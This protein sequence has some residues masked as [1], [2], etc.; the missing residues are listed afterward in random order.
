MEGFFD[1]LDARQLEILKEQMKRFESF[2]GEKRE[3]VIIDGDVILPE[4][5]LIHGTPFNEK[6]LEN[7]AKS[8]I[9]TGEY[10]G[11]SEDGETFYHADF[12]RVPKETSLREYN[13]NFTYW[14]GRCPFGKKS[15]NT[16]AFVIH[17]NSK[18][19]EIASY[20]C[21][22]DETKEA[23]KAKTF[24]N[25][26]GLPTNDKSVVSSILFGVP[27]CFI[28]GIV[29]GDNKI[30]EENIKL[31]RSLFPDCYIV[32]NNG[33]IICGKENDNDEIISLRIETIKTEIESEKLKGT[34][35]R[36][37]DTIKRMNNDA[38]TMWKAIADLPLEEVA[39]IYKIIGWQGDYVEF[40]KHLKETYKEKGMIR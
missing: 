17:P 30:T 15:K 38:D 23:E 5:T 4:G 28:N 16:I 18:L 6:T 26:N 35:K 24:V 34:I 9:I 20:D 40:A 33:K 21:Y 32:R 10:F 36:L 29:V 2:K 12:H 7:I 8:G 27:S 19:Q 14:D 37:E 3:Q 39:L 13:D 31:L 1:K 25:L 22:K 11:I